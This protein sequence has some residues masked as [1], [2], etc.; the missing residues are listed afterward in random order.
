[1]A[2]NWAAAVP[3]KIYRSGQIPYH[4]LRE[5]LKDFR[6]DQ[7]VRRNGMVESVRS[8]RAEYDAPRR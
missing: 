8:H 6:I 2:P 5:R 7:I 4:I 3:G 1:M